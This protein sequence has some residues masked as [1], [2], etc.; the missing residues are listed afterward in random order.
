MAQAVK[1]YQKALEVN[2]D[3]A[4]ADNIRKMLKANGIKPNY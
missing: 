1:Y 3:Y 2:P 4:N